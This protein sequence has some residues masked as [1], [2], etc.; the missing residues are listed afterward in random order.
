MT[1]RSDLNPGA[2][3]NNTASTFTTN[4]PG[5]FAGERTSA[6]V[7]STPATITAPTALTFAKTLVSTDLAITSGNNVVVGETATY[8][9]ATTIQQGLTQIVTIRDTLPAGL[10]YVSGTLVF[11]A[12]TSGA[13]AVGAVSNTAYVDGSVINPADISYTPGTGVLI[14]SLKNVQIPATSTN[15]TG[16]IAVDFNAKVNTAATNIGGATLINT[17]SASVDRNADG[18]AV[19]A[20]ETSANSTHTLTILEPSLAIAKSFSAASGDA[21]N[22]VRVTVTVTNNGTSGAYDTQVSDAIN[23]TS[24]DLA[25]F[26]AVTT[27]AGWTLAYNS[28]TGALK[29]GRAHV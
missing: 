5:T 23:G 12:V 6:T 11:R 21:G 20:G 19:D 3:I 17:A 27:P 1:L 22:V 10:D 16:T 24:F 18:D 15:G 28:T 25:S 2:I 8:R 13:T 26:S 7:T 4:V 9:L 29:I 14:I